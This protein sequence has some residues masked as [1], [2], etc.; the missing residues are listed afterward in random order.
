MVFPAAGVR[1]AGPPADGD[2]AH[3]IAYRTSVG[4]RADPEFVANAEQDAAGYPH[5]EFG[6]A[7]SDAE[8]REIMRR[9][10][11]GASID[12]AEEFAREHPTFA[13]VY[14]DQLDRGTPVFLFAD[15]PE[16]HRDALARRL[17]AGMTFR[18]ERAAWTYRSLLEL[19]DRIDQDRA[20]LAKRGTN[21]LL[22]ALD[23]RANKLIVGVEALT[24]ELSSALALDYGTGVVVRDEQRGSADV[25][26]D[27]YKD[28]FPLKGGVEIKAKADGGACTAGFL[29]KRAS[30]GTF[31]LLTAGH[32][33]AAHGYSGKVWTHGGRDLGTSG[34]NTW[35]AESPADAGFVNLTAQVPSDRNNVLLTPSPYV[36]VSIT[37]IDRTQRQ[38]DPVCRNGITSGHGCGHI[39][40][41]VA[42]KQSCLPS[43]ACYW[44]TQQVLVDF[45]S[46]GGDSGGP[47]QW[48]AAGLGIHVHSDPDNAANPFG[49][50]T[51]A[52]VASDH[53]A[54]RFGASYR[55]KFCL[56]DACTVTYP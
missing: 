47:Y 44:L 37:S 8:F 46:R 36:E 54:T 4:F 22:I 28:C 55:Y 34:A 39:A 20:A 14:I 48:I 13:G 18:V 27:T 50:Y 1:S 29:T 23:T 11:V 38:G 5:R 17:P 45:D 16:I 9:S 41:E 2:L 12:E 21:V 52:D 25:C 26:V 43:G 40:A 24:A 7:L 42:R 51:R 53:F 56:N 31:A 32:C 33:F 6:L 15:D 35:A 19:M 30:T 3:A 49:W 10:D